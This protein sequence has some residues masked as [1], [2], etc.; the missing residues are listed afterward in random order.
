MGVLREFYK[1]AFCVITVVVDELRTEFRPI[2]K[3]LGVDIRIKPVLVAKPSATD[4]AGD[5]RD[6]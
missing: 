5:I 1:G 4:V 2:V 6:F 3:D